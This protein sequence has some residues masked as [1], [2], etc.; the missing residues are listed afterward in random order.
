M[1]KSARMPSST[2][3][4]VSHVVVGVVGT[5]VVG[6]AIVKVLGIRKGALLYQLLA[7]AALI[8]LHYE[9]D[10]PVAKGLS[11]LGV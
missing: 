4:G 3:K 1:A 10:M 11:E 5:L 7:G 2:A 8:G 9:F 6:T